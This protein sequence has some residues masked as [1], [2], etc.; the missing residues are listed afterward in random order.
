M[1]VIVDSDVLIGVLRGQAGAR[2]ALNEA[3]RVGQRLMS[4]TP[5][6]VEILRGVLPGEEAATTALLGLIRWIAVDEA[7]AD[8]AGELG[9]AFRHSHPRIEVADLLLAAATERLGA[10]LLTRNVR[11]LSDA[12]GARAGVLTRVGR[13]RTGPVRRAPPRG[14]CSGRSAGSRTT[15]RRS[16]RAWRRSRRSGFAPPARG[17]L[18]GPRRAA[19]RSGSSRAQGPPP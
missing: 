5:V 9:H 2:S 11:A 3:R 16:S 13:P 12:P 4:V 7:L 1:T 8:R 17:P 18:R 15:G 14:T 6:R 19:R 10:T